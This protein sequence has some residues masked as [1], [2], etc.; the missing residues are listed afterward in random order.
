MAGA[1][2]RARRYGNRNPNSQESIRKKST[3]NASSE[4]KESENRF[5]LLQTADRNADGL[6]TAEFVEAALGALPDRGDTSLSD[7]TLGDIV[8]AV[9][10]ALVPVITAAVRSTAIGGPTTEKIKSNVQVNAFAVNSLEQYSR[11]ENIK[12][13]GFPESDNEDTIDEV[14]NLL[15]DAILKKHTETYG[16]KEET[17]EKEGED[18]DRPLP[19]PPLTISRADISTAHR[20]P[21]KRGAIKPIVARFVRRETREHVMRNR[22][23]LKGHPKGKIFVYDDLTRLNDKRLWALRNDDNIDKAYSMNSVIWAVTKPGTVAAES[24]KFKIESPDDLLQTGMSQD[25]IASLEL[26]HKY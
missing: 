16:E 1:D 8:T 23:G 17:G 11:R 26:Y 7:S 5:Q 18:S 3:S 14:V 15:N 20:C 9:V 10:N 24:R 25:K 12:I 19:P 2:A 6:D 4:S 22:G 21:T 13:V